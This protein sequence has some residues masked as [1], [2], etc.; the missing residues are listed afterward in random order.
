MLKNVYALVD[1]KKR[2]EAVELQVQ[3]TEGVCFIQRIEIKGIEIDL[4]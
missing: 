3:D 2:G 1:R 4:L